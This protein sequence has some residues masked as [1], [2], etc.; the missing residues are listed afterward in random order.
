MSCYRCYG[1]RSFVSRPLI[2]TSLYLFPALA[3]NCG[4]IVEKLLR[5]GG[6][7]FHAVYAT[8]SSQTTPVI[9]CNP[10]TCGTFQLKPAK[11][12]QHWMVSALCI[13]VETASA[14]CSFVQWRSSRSSCQPCCN[15]IHDTV[16]VPL[17]RSSVTVPLKCDVYTR[18]LSFLRYVASSVYPLFQ[19]PCCICSRYLA[20]L[21][22]S[23]LPVAICNIACMFALLLQNMLWSLK[24]SSH[25]YLLKTP[26]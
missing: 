12:Q 3:G 17:I 14:G 15:V 2:P 10:E 25:L 9:E 6:G 26:L 5:S 23:S 8:V 13:N 1:I 19:Q 16:P 24:Y 4:N 21:C 7:G 11:L 18:C 20:T 22:S